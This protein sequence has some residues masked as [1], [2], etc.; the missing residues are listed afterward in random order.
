[1]IASDTNILVRYI[2]NDDPVQAAQAIEL[3]ARADDIFVAKTVLLEL[4]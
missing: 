2:T 1:M 4:E 3:M